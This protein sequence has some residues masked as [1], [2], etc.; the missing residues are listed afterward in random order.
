[1]DSMESITYEIAPGG[2]IEIVLNKPNEQNIIPRLRLSTDTVDRALHGPKFENPPCKGRYAVFSK[3]YED[4]RNYKVLVRVSSS[5]L[6][7]ASRVFRVMLE[8]PWKEGASSSE[9]FRQINTTGWDALAFVVVL[10]AIHGRHR[11]IPDKPTL[12]LV[13]RIATVIDYY[14]CHDA[15]YV[16]FDRWL[17]HN[18]R[19]SVSQHVLYKK[20]LLCLYI[21][22]VFSDL[23]MFNKMAEVVFRH[24]E[25]LSLIDT[26]DIPLGGALGEIRI[27]SIS[28]ARKPLTACR[29]DRRTK[30]KVPRIPLRES[31][32]CRDVPAQRYEMR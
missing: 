29:T 16:Y 7:F 32:S 6:K 3:L 23:G 21:A 19:I 24:S 17:N 9:P 15:L 28:L 31:R 20:T 5:H 18:P 12:G 2:D 11:E 8:G 10:D 25:G 27:L 1:M 4:P 22:T 14:E 30:T 26:S 13:T